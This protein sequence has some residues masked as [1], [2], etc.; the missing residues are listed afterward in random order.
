M[1]GPT[2]AESE[3]AGEGWYMNI[4]ALITVTSLAL[5]GAASTPAQEWTFD[6]VD[7][8]VASAMTGSPVSLMLDGDG[9]PHI[10]YTFALGLPHDY[11]YAWHDGAE[12]H[13]ETFDSFPHIYGTFF[14][15]ISLALDEHSR[16]HIAYTKVDDPDSELLYAFHDGEA[17]QIEKITDAYFSLWCSIALDSYGTPHV[18]FYDSHPNRDL[19]YATRTNL[20]WI[21]EP[22]DTVGWVGYFSRLCLDSQDHPHIAYRHGDEF[23][24]K[25]A[26]HDGTDWSIATVYDPPDAIGTGIALA[27]DSQ[28]RPHITCTANTFT[29]S[30]RYSHLD[31]E[32]WH[33]ETVGDAGRSSQTSIALDTNDRPHIAYDFSESDDGPHD[34]RYA[35]FDGHALLRVGQN[36]GFP[37][38]RQRGSTAPNESAP[39]FLRPARSVHDLVFALLLSRAAGSS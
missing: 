26:H 2:L 31:G 21:I 11:R 20:G 23:T 27:L 8:G 19:H 5:L 10:A 22:V 18:A 12:W 24:V 39:L 32:E 1:C 38:D 37:R 14:A 4:L 28:D 3:E 9:N 7:G 17:W 34:H 6:V 30:L 25:Y 36:D 33:H 29:N 35:F 16:P 13:T 15:G